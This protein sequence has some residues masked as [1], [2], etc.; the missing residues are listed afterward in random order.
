[1]SSFICDKCHAEIIDTE[2]GYITGCEH[3]QKDDLIEYSG[4]LISDGMSQVKADW[5]AIK[6][7]QRLLQKGEQTAIW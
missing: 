1:M 7:Q 5:E 2:N 3:Y 4:K 6:A